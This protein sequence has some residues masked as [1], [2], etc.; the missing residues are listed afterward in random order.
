MKALVRL[1]PRA[2]RD[3]YEA[4]VIDLLDQRRPSFRDA[5]DLVVGAVDAHLHPQVGSAVIPWTW[6]L[7]GLAVLAAG[8]TWIA[9]T[10]AVD[11]SGSSSLSGTFLG[12][13][14]LAMTVGLPGDYAIR[15]SRA[16][17]AVVGLI[18]AG[19]V[20]AQIAPYPVAV[21]IAVATVVLFLAGALALAAV[22]AEIGSTARWALVVGTTI[23]PA[24]ALIPFALGLL[25]IDPPVLT[26]R[27]LLLPY[28][29]A[30]ILLGLRL[31][32]RGSQSIV[33]PPT[34][35]ETALVTAPGR[36]A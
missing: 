34:G 15:R 24:L 6:R 14:L 1:Y 28:G 11:A 26:I 27:W 9:A 22:R 4:E 21:V 23:V 29:A 3:R 7:P 36:S 16:I 30:W 10:V 32:V 35:V 25:A 31:V 20:V 2:W 18:A 19:V 33:D 5:L 17:L 13:S 12:L 8:A